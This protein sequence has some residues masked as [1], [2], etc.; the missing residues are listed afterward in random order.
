MGGQVACEPIVTE[1]LWNQVNQIIEEQLKSWKRPGPL[2]VQT[3]GNLTQCACGTKM[4][5]RSG[6]P[7]Y[8]CRAC[9]NKIPMVD[10][11]G[12]IHD[13][14]K[15][16]FAS[17]AKLA[18]HAEEAKRNLTTKEQ[19]LAA[20]EREIAR[21]REDMSRTHRLYLDGH[22]TP[23]G[24]GDFYKPAEERLNQLNASLPK[25]QAEVDGLRMTEVSSEEVLAE[26]T[27]LYDRWPSMATD[28]KRRIAEALIEKIVVGDGEIDITFS[29]LPTSE[30]QCKSQQQ[31]RGPG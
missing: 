15:A 16:F 23:Q 5:V 30:E 8:V 12:V 7:K 18:S 26:A 13:E 19:A 9:R 11:E 2:P 1:M 3:F 20:H 10:L 21:V 6:S 25:L 28:E 27:A 29:Y 31:W 4:Y 22:V 24:F 14:L 17:P